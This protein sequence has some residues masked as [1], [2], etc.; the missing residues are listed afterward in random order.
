[1]SFIADN[2]EISKLLIKIDTYY[3]YASSCRE[4]PYKRQYNA[5]IGM[6]KGVKRYLGADLQGFHIRLGLYCQLEPALERYVMGPDYDSGIGPYP[7]V[8]PEP[9]DN[10]FD[11]PVDI[12]SWHHDL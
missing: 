12:P 9:Y 5:Y 4:S 11:T 6:V 1:M 3:D 7:R 10:E 8:F 2:F